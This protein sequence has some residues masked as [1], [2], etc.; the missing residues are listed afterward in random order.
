MVMALAVLVT[1][2]GLFMFYLQATCERVLRREFERDYS[3][4]LVKSVRLE[5]LHV[6]NRLEQQS[7]PVNHAGMRPS[8]QADFRA[9]TF[10]MKQTK[11]P[12]LR[13]SVEVFLLR[14]YFRCLLLSLAV[15][16]LMNLGERAAL[17]KL[18]R[19][20][21]HFSNELGQ[22]WGELGTASQTP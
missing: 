20:L 14:G 16:P 18:S 21:E 9:L 5:F 10:L 12:S 15:V 2:A 11:S 1:S 7:Q 13:R 4:A 19:I 8:L 17:S 6:R 3:Q 22:R